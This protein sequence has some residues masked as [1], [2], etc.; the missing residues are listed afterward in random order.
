MSITF[1]TTKQILKKLGGDI[2]R[3]KVILDADLQIVE[4][5][6]VEGTSFYEKPTNI[7]LSEGQTYTVKLDSGTYADVCKVMEYE[8]YPM[9][10]IGNLGLVGLTDNGLP[11]MAYWLPAVGEHEDGAQF[12]L[13]DAN[14]GSHITISEA[15]TV[16][17]ID[18]KY[19]PEEAT[20]KVIDFDKYG[21]SDVMLTLFGQGG[22][23]YSMGDQSQFWAELTGFNQSSSIIVKFT[24]EPFSS[25]FRTTNVTIGRD[26][27]TL[28]AYS[29]STEIV[30][31]YE[32]NPM[33]V[34]VVAN[35]TGDSGTNVVLKLNTA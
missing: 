16:H 12:S 26:N 35:D 13:I 20:P 23:E 1:P 27:E 5:G 17:P 22:G 6:T 28:V 18:P 10:Y 8:G 24:F 7:T 32:G 21:I 25:E 33:R 31:M 14:G 29:L 15:E 30:V 19:L 11:F 2:E 4:D 3:A 34:V 9:H